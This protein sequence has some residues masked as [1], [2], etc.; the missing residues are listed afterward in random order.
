MERE[1]EK[2]SD[3][4]GVVLNGKKIIN[5]TLKK[6]S[7]EWSP[8]TAF[9]MS[10]SS[11]ALHDKKIMDWDL[12]LDCMVCDESHYAKGINS[13]RTKAV[14]VL[15]KVVSST[16]LLSGTPMRN[17]SIDL[18]PQLHMV[19][20]EKYPDFFEYADKYSPPRERTFGRSTVLHMINQQICLS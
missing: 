7:S 13:K 10:W 20:P 12:H 5:K 15:S 16:V 14:M 2:W 11:I 9:I 4:E 18:F 8:K 1:I 3:W 6:D 19:A 17:C